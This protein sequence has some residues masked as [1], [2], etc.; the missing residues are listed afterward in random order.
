MDLLMH[1]CT[2][3]T[4]EDRAESL[5]MCGLVAHNIVRERDGGQLWYTFA[6]SLL[7][8]NDML[9]KIA[10]HSLHAF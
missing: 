9:D 1:G 4:F 6:H 10:Q 8:H 5:C 3:L 7:V 2:S